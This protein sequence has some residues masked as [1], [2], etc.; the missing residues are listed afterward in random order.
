MNFYKILSIDG[1]GIR[2]VIPAMVLTELEARTGKPVSALFDLIAGTSTGG[3]LAV[4][5][6]APKT[7]EADA[8]T[9][10]F[11]AA[12]LLALYEE[13]GRDIFS[14]S[15]LNR[16]TSFWGLAD[17]RYSSAGLDA[18]LQ[19]FLGDLEL[20]DAL[21]EVLV[22]SY[23]LEARR[24]YF[25]K[26]SKARKVPPAERENYRLRDVARATTAT[27]TYFEPARV[28]PVGDAPAK[29]R[30]LID[31]G[32][33]ANNPA[34]CAYAEA[35]SLGTTP[36]EVLLVSLGTGVMDRPIPYDEA[37]DWGFVSWI[38]PVLNVMMDGMADAVDYQ[39]RQMLP[40]GE[41]E[42]RYYRFDV[43]LQ[44]A[45]DDLDAAHQANITALKHDA[46]RLLKDPS[47]GK[48]FEAL[49]RQ[50]AA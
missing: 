6:T 4:G 49:C 29:P 12:E 45:L 26:R 36:G 32:V 3:F 16:I 30:Y 48:K 22:P 23:E 35:I 44:T 8:P 31:G 11:T 10:R 33:F 18:V 5:L 13:R 40:T 27:P 38:R 19:E 2:G 50:L 21:T 1:G 43:R 34:L 41:R 25:F 47:T 42:S 37:K 14:R 28:F 9:P 7:A 39:L 46:N 24:P 20:K 17:E 15:L